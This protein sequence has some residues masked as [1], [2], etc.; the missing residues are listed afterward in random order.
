MLECVLYII[1]QSVIIYNVKE[2]DKYLETNKIEMFQF[3]DEFLLRILHFSILVVIASHTNGKS[4]PLL[5]SLQS[6]P[7]NVQCISFSTYISAKFEEC[8]VSN[9]I[10][11]R[12]M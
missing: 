4:P 12:L 11:I 7:Y 3:I 8:R 5:Y 9:I 1:L 10:I 6:A 2:E